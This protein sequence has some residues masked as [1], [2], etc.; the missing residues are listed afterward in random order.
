MQVAKQQT[1]P[2][3]SAVEVEDAQVA[4]VECHL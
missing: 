2:F 1:C 3:V 4:D